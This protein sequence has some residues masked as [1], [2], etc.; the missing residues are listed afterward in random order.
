[1][2]SFLI[3]QKL[4]HIVTGYI[5]KPIKQNKEKD[6]KFI[7]RLE[8]WDSKNHKIITWF[9][10]TSIPAIHAQLMLLMIIK[11]SG[12]FLFTRFKS[13]G[14]AHYY[15]LQSTLVN[16]HQDIGQSVNE[17]LAILQHIWTQ[18]DQAKISN[19]HLRLIKVLM[20]LRPKYESVR[21]A[22]LHLSPLPSLDATIQEI[23]FE[24]KCLDINPAKHSN[25]VL[26]STYPPNK[27]SNIFCKNCKLS[28]HKFI[29]YPKI[30][31]RYC[32]KR[33]HILDNCP[34]TPPRPT[35]SSTK[36]KN[37]TKLGTFSIVAAT[38]DDSTFPLQISDLQS[39]LNK[40]IS[41]SSALVVHQVTDGFLAL[42]VVTI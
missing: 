23:L 41:S 15:Q 8:D 20:R 40:L 38:S 3:G 25:V 21:A 17:Y 18:L 28:G 10:N 7:E 29:D 13:I 32:H 1:M 37:F 35:G 34:T 12:F 22:L 6:N 9:G 26:P 24:E 11:S 42:P 39:L 31:C 30:K 33:G 36:D 4:W 14:L 2:K 19:D 16:L 27:A 5:T